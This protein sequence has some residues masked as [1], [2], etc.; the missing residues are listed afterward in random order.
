MTLTPE[1][2]VAVQAGLAM[3]PDSAPTVATIDVPVLAIAGGEDSA[4]TPTEMEAFNAAP[5]GCEFYLL[6][7]AGHFAAYEQPQ[8]VSALMEKWMWQA[9]G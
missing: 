2:A 9:V 6:P 8:K 4:V 7:D 1:A 3:R 5:G